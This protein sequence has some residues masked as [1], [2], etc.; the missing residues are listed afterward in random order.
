MPGESSGGLTAADK[1]LLLAHARAA[2]LTEVGA[3]RDPSGE[4]ADPDTA[5]LAGP[6]AAFVTLH[7]GGALRGCI[8]TSERRQPLWHV[9]GEMAGAAA[10]RDPRFPLPSSTGRFVVSAVTDP[11]PMIAMLVIIAIGIH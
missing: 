4:R 6:G 11:I 9:V 1:R 10:T 7:V 8:G 3:D 5:A 2:V